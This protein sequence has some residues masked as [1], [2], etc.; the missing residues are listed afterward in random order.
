M[1]FLAFDLG[2]ES[3]RA[4]VGS[5]DEG[6]LRIREILRFAN[7]MITE[8]DGSLH[9]DAGML[10]EN[11][12]EGMRRCRDI[13]GGP[14]QSLGVDTWGVD[15]GLL[16]AEDGLLGLP[17]SYRDRRT[18]GAME[19]F[20][21]FLPKEEVYRLTGIQFL[22]FNTLF[23]LYALVRDRSPL[24]RRASALLFMPD[25]FHFLLTG[26][27]ATEFSIATTSQLFDPRR[28]S[29]SPEVF[30]ALGLPPDLMQPVVDPGTVIAPLLDRLG[31]ETGLGPC[32]VVASLTHD[33]AAAVAAVPS[34]GHDWAYISSG[35]WSLVGVET[36]EAIIN[37]ESLSLNFTNEG[38]LGRTIRFLKNVTGLWL[39]QQC[40]KVWE[41]RHP[42]ASWDYAS[43]ARAAEEAAPF[44]TLLDP[45]DPA[46]LNPEDMTAAIEAYAR[47]T[48]QPL[49]ETPGAFVRCILESLALKYASV[50]DDLERLTRRSIETVHII[51]GGARN[52]LL[53]RL[54]AS[55]CGRTVV[56]GPDEATSC[57]NL[58]GQALALGVIRTA[59][60]A[61]E[62]M[63]NSFSTTVRRPDHPQVWERTRAVYQDLIRRR[64]SN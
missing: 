9:W 29:W 44:R 63:R 30:E 3:G 62:I 55:A 2:A 27:K 1:S 8:P 20:F 59:A 32:P 11:I 58:L 12:K 31:A 60:Q 22:S 57:G 40:R 42:S 33:T 14:P 36:D 45:D 56:A 13:L 52:D 6:R 15:F 54:T 26:E 19:E 28:D 38:G 41:R 34:R 24:L 23:Q 51:G 25:L 7:R 53:N 61:R 49:P 48:G 39:V 16:D 43:L 21:G 5:L 50:L 17:F 64:T 46:F 18:E 37:D 10:F 47:N 35:T 4:V